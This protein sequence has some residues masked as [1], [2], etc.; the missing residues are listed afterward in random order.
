[1]KIIALS[2]NTTQKEL[3]AEHGLSLY[4]EAQGMKILFDFGASEL[5]CENA[6]RLG[7]DLSLVDF[8]VLSHGHNDH[9]GGIKRFLEINHH[10]KIYASSHAFEPHY[11]AMGEYIGLDIELK[12]HNTRFVFVDTEL[13]P[14]LGTT[15]FNCNHVAPLFPINECGHTYKENGTLLPE[16]YR[17]EQYLLIEEQGKRVLFSGCSHKGILN[18]MEWVKPTHLIGGFHFSKLPLDSNLKSTVDIL[19]SYMAKYYTCHCTGMEQFEFMK[20]Q[21]QDLNYLACGDEINI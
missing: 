7:V 4:I 10:A 15:L 17:H 6:R 18:I 16:N 13:Q 3:Q 9:G 19:N 5:F 20:N 21:M 1:M 8:A 14:G 11:N 12:K 2:E